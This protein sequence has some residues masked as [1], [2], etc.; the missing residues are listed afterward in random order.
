MDDSYDW[1]VMSKEAEWEVDEARVLEAYLVRPSAAALQQWTG[2]GAFLCK[3]LKSAPQ[4]IEIVGP[5]P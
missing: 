1:F 2:Q 5:I 3:V 4:G